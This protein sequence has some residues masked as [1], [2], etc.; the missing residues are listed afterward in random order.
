MT[1]PE[2]VVAVAWSSLVAV[3]AVAMWRDRGD[4]TGEVWAVAFVVACMALVAFGVAVL[5]GG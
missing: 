1:A 4:A 3:C 2:A 5:L